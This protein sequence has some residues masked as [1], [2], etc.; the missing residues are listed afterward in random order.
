MPVRHDAWQ[1]VRGGMLKRATFGG[2]K[3]LRD[4]A[5][6]LRPFTVLIGPNGVG[7]STVLDGISYLLELAREQPG[8]DGD[9]FSRAGVVFRE[10][11][12]LAELLSRPGSTTLSLEV[13][14]GAG[15]RF[16]FMGCAGAQGELASVSISY[17]Q[18]RLTLPDSQINPRLFWN[19]ADVRSL[20]SF[21]RLG[22]DARQIRKPSLAAVDEHPV[23]REDGFGLPTVLDRLRESDEKDKIDQDLQRILNTA[24]RGV[25]SP[26]GELRQTRARAVPLRRLVPTD[27]RIKG[28]QAF[29]EDAQTPGLSL[30]L[31]YEELGWL[32]ARHVSEGTLL[33]LALL[34]VIHRP[35]RPKLILLDDIDRGLHPQ[36]QLDLVAILR[37]VVALYPDVQIIAT[38][39]SPLVIAACGKDEVQSLSFDATGNTRVDA[40]EDVPAIMTLSEIVETWF[41]IS[42]TGASDLLQA[43]ALL[44]GDAERTDEQDLESR[45]LLKELRLLGADPG[46]TPVKRRKK[47]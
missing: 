11:R 25:R 2:L 26:M 30:E 16:G 4:V 7:K 3:A 32:P 38:A 17:G 29:V 36:A 1:G 33:A 27:I 39:H 35:A 8:E 47:A 12:S 23:M 45:R 31:R 10:E 19:Q 28:E 6:P 18:A 37:S 20:G 42:R 34:T 22:L 43:Y 15:G 13:E 46:W 24:R 5:V 41:N 40:V 14:T 21:V 44:A 9:T